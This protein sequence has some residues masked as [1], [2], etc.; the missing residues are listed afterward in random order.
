MSSR[1]NFLVFSKAII[2][3]FFTKVIN[4]TFYKMQMSINFLSA[5]AVPC[6]NYSYSLGSETY[7]ARKHIPGRYMNDA[8]SLLL[9]FTRILVLYIFFSNIF[10]P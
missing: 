10:N 2:L 4:N 1:H 7:T 5:N 6:V 9:T 8:N 3:T